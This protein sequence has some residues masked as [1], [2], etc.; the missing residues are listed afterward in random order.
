MLCGMSDAINPAIDCC[1]TQAYI[2]SKNN[3]HCECYYGG[4]AI[5]IEYDWLNF[6]INKPRPQIQ[7]NTG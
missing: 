3:M 4:L 1:L 2:A 5:T 7:S 6:I